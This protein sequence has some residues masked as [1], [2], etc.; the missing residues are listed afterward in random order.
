M[1][2]AG[3]LF[4]LIAATILAS[5]FIGSRSGKA[6]AV[7]VLGSTSVQPFAEMLAQE[8]QKQRPDINVEV[9]GGGSTAGIEAIRSGITDIGTCSRELK[10]DETFRKVE[11]ARDALAI[12]VHWSNPMT[13]LTRD[14]IRRIFNGQISDWREV[15][16]ADGPIR[17]ITREE[18]S[19]T[20]E[21]FMKLVMGGDRIARKAL[22]QESNGAVKELVKHDPYAIGYMSLGLVHGEAKILAVDGVLPN[23]DTVLAKKYKLTRP[24]YFVLNERR[25]PGTDEFVKFVLSPAGQAL[26]EGQGLVGVKE[27]DR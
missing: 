24:F 14:R 27:G 10:P 8:F 2:L 11:I 4:G 13:D 5:V 3:I 21:A 9:Q 20:R 22:T 6:G 16:G 25:A 15:G 18:G 12:V 23:R 7:S 26:L 19:G 1:R 17:I